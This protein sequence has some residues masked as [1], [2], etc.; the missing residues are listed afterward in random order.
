MSAATINFTFDGRALKARP[1]Q[2]LAAALLDNG[3]KLVARS[4]KYHRPRGILSAGVEEPNALVTVGTGGRTEPNTRATD[5][6]VYEGL[7]AT[8]QNRWPSLSSDL[9]CALQLVSKA[10][11]AGFY[12]KTFFGPPKLWLFYEK[13]IRRAAGLGPAPIEIDPDRYATRAA[14]C[15][16]LVVGS[17]PAG[18]IAARDAVRAGRKVFLV[19]QDAELAPSL[20]RDPQEIEGKPGRTWAGEIATEVRTSGGRV[21]TRTSASGLWDDQ[22]ICLS[23]KLV[24]PG[25]VPANGFTQRYWHVRA[26]E[27]VLATGAIERPLTFA[28]NDRPGVML[29][30]AVRTYVNRFGVVP[31]QR[32]VLATTNDDAYLTAKALRDAGAEVVAVL[33]SRPAPAGQNSGFAVFNSAVPVTAKGG[34]NGVTALVADLDATQRTFACDLIAMSGGFTP[35]VH[36][37]MQ[38]GGKLDWDEAAQAFVPGASRWNVRTVGLAAEPAPAETVGATGAAKQAFVDFQNDVTVADL[39]LAWR[40]GYRSVE[41]LKRYTTLGMATDQGKTGNMAALDRIARREGMTVPEAGLTTFRPPYTPVS[42]GALAGLATGEHAQPTRRPALVDL[43]AA[44]Y[45]IWL[46]AGYWKRP[47]AYPVG[48][49]TLA[50]AGLREARAVRTTVGMC[51]VSTLA[52]FEVQGPDAVQFLERVCQTS[53]GKL[54]IGRGRYTFMAREDGLVFDDGTVWQLEENRY[55]LTSSTGGASRMA[56]WLS[57]VRHHLCAD[58]KVSVVCVQEHYAAIAVAGPKS[59]EVMAKLTGEEAPR[60]MSVVEARIAGIPAWVMAASFSGERAFEV[61]FD[62]AHADAVWNAIEAMGCTPYGLEAMELLRIEKGHMVVGPD[63]DGR[64][65]ADE[66]GLGKMVNKA[67]GWIGAAALHRPDFADP[68]RKHFVGLE[69]IDGGSI[70]EGSMLVRWIGGEAEGHVTGSGLRVLEGSSIAIGHLKGGHK[71]H[72]EELFACSP[73]R[74]QK[75]RVRVTSPHFYDPAGERYRD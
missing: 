22:F 69:A 38:A 74:K 15:D 3:I 68:L 70:P 17:G 53:V 25:Q 27:V 49:E 13:F 14:F 60:H 7:V 10:L 43:H 37:H 44:K 41:H 36:L 52:K 63:I 55:L 73:T 24:E 9:G 26:G 31:G 50:Q 12:Y 64:L 32:V 19:E 35:V 6:Y 59:R 66:L 23:E 72:D 65:T 61:H 21:L 40:E 67:G 71:R 11:P 58:L 1:G 57:Y 54:A 62:A 42:M 75:A 30:Q 47:R 8:S 48:G 29:S 5:L 18:L 33:D 39:D 56:T 45:P 46:N 28:N 34:K 2:T 4:F 16:V 51:D 20:L